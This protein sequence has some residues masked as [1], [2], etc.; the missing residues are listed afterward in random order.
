MEEYNKFMSWY[1]KCLGAWLVFLAIG[2][3]MPHH[4]IQRRVALFIASVC[5]SM[6]LWNSIK[7]AR[8]LKNL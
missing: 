7:A 8:I 1:L 6:A 3:F 5:I 2:L 4:S